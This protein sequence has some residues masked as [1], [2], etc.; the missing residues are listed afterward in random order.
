MSQP[1]PEEVRAQ[2]QEYWDKKAAQ[3]AAKQQ[4]ELEAQASTQEGAAQSP[5][6]AQS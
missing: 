4:K 2:L 1:L 6:S 5:D 3:A